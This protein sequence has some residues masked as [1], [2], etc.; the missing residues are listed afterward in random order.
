MSTCRLGA[1]HRSLDHFHD[2]ATLAH[3]RAGEST[4]SVIRAVPNRTL[5]N[6]CQGDLKHNSMSSERV[7]LGASQVLADLDFG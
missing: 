6:V 4:E 7:S 2:N 5:P 3:P 1:L